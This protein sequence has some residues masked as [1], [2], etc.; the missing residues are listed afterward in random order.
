MRLPPPPPHPTPHAHSPPLTP[1][2]LACPTPA[3]FIA[4]TAAV[5]GL[6]THVPV[7]GA[8]GGGKENRSAAGGRGRSAASQGA[9]PRPRPR[10]PYPRRGPAHDRGLHAW[11]L[12]WRGG[13]TEWSGWARTPAGSAH[14][15]LGAARAQRRPALLPLAARSAASRSGSLSCVAAPAAHPPATR[16]PPLTAGPTRCLTSLASKVEARP[17]PHA[18]PGAPLSHPSHTRLPRILSLP[19]SPVPADLGHRDLPGPPP[20]HRLPALLG[21]ARHRRLLPPGAQGGPDQGGR[22]GGRWRLPA[23]VGRRRRQGHRRRLCRRRRRG[24]HGGAG[25]PLGARLCVQGAWMCGAVG[26]AGGGQGRVGAT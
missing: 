6:A 2:C 15:V 12:R 25:A 3:L 17:L 8:R 11:P 1:P 24:H 14:A 4:W 21:G 7:R 5:M 9:H 26:G 16:P 22:G 20:R 19:P 13:S 23:V 18:P 10:R